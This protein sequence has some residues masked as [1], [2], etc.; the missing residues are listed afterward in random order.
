MWSIE[1]GPAAA[2]AH[3]AALEIDGVTHAFGLREPHAAATG[4]FAG[5]ECRLRQVHGERIVQASAI[6]RPDAEADG[7]WDWVQRLRDKYLAVRTADCV[8]ILFAS[9]DGALV[10]AVHAGWRGTAQGIAAKAVRVLE[11]EGC[12]PGKLIAAVGP[13][14]GVCCYPV[15]RQ[16]AA[17]VAEASSVP[18]EAVTR[19]GPGQVRLDLK[20]A[21]GAQLRAAGVPDHSVHSA[22]W[23][24]ACEK[25]LFFSFRRDGAAAGRQLSLIGPQVPRP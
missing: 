13:S 16:V 10:G 9:R 1:R 12:P 4:R 18:I 21:I 22:P 17:D 14:I 6:E 8:P 2:Y 19:C 5:R 23:C 3:C 25:D 24:T 15:S 11:R 7:S 20:L